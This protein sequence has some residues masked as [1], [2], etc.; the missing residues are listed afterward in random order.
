MAELPVQVV[1]TGGVM[2][3]EDLVMHED[4]SVSLR[5]SIPTPTRSLEL[6]QAPNTFMSSEFHGLE[7]TASEIFT[8]SEVRHLEFAA[9]EPLTTPEITGLP[10]IDDSI[11]EA[12]IP[13]ERSNFES[14]APEPQIGDSALETSTPTKDQILEYETSGSLTPSTSS[15]LKSTAPNTF[16][17]FPHLPTELRLQI[18][19]HAALVPRNIDL[20]A[21]P[22]PPSTP[23][24]KVG[25]GPTFRYSTLASVPSLLGVNWEARGVGLGVW[26]LG[27]KEPRGDDEGE[28]EKSE[29]R[30]GD[31]RGIWV[32]WEL[33][34][35]VPMD[36]WRWE[37]AALGN[38]FE[39]KRMRH[40]ALNVEVGEWRCAWFLGLRL[41]TLTLYLWERSFRLSEVLD[42]R[43]NSGFEVGFEAIEVKSREEGVAWRLDELE[44]EALREARVKVEYEFAELEALQSEWEGR[45]D[46]E[47]FGSAVLGSP[48]FG[49][50]FS[51][52]AGW[53]KGEEEVGE[54]RERPRVQ[55]RSVRMGGRE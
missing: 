32:N 25:T 14:S 6:E 44:M 35:V 51:R 55:F 2:E 26:E 13:A 19:T 53:L 31:G 39:E 43:S 8:P 47:G 18:W 29:S 48:V 49:N 42:H 46:E 41:Q 24:N 4:G 28:G 16:T 30:D 3:A 36:L 17:L 34:T 1:E 23:L 7:F 38:L 12:P 9:R 22:I 33:D 54:R 50:A 40:L 11:P 45:E 10:L 5:V 21:L 37:N 27:F 15:H 52:S 20:W